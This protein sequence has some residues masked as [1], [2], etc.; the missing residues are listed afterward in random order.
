VAF[1]LVLTFLASKIA[2]WIRWKNDLKERI[3]QKREEMM[4]REKIRKERFI[5]YLFFNFS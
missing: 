5:S 3:I 1:F 4:P 2:Y